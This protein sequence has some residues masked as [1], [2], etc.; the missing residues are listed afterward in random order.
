MPSRAPYLLTTLTEDEDNVSR[1]SESTNCDSSD[2]YL[3]PE[4]LRNLHL[5]S[6]IFGHL[7]IN[8][9]CNKFELL[10]SIIEGKIDILIVFETKLDETFSS[11]QFF[12]K[13]FPLLSR[14]F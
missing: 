6:L 9:I 7:N 3:K 10:Y 1:S 12:S 4:K 14:G 2:E 8:S 13:G 5:K 11:A